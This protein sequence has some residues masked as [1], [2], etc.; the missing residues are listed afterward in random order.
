MTS[1]KKETMEPPSSIR[2]FSNSSPKSF[3][4]SGRH[5]CTPTLGRQCFR[6][7][8]LSRVCNHSL[9][10]N[11][12]KQQSRLTV[13]ATTANSLSFLFGRTV[14][15]SH[16]C[17]WQNLQGKLKDQILAFLFFFKER[18]VCNSPGL[19]NW[20]ITQ[21]QNKVWFLLLQNERQSTTR[22]CVTV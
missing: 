17:G 1:V 5:T 11:Y 2:S 4:H 9:T 22:K 19:N 15:W 18:C 12:H 7:C 10:T 21:P 16:E 8:T 3:I 13:S 14:L 20:R 6:L